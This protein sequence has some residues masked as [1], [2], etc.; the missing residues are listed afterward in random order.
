MPLHSQQEIKS[1]LVPTNFYLSND[2]YHNLKS[3]LLREGKVLEVDV[4]ELHVVGIEGVED[5]E[6]VLEAHQ[7]VDG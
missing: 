6:V 7:G 3:L 1:A 5:Q 2:S 4:V